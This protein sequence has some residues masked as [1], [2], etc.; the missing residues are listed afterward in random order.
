MAPERQVFTDLKTLG[1]NKLDDRFGIGAGSL[2]KFLD[3]ALLVPDHH[4]WTEYVG[5]RVKRS[6]DSVWAIMIEEWCKQ[7]LDNQVAQDFIAKVLE[8]IDR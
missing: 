2:F 8:S 4:T 3:D 5:D 1:W 7:C 6:K